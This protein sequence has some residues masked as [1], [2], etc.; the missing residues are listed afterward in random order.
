MLIRKKFCYKGREFDAIS[1]DTKALDSRTLFVK[2]DLNAKYTQDLVLEFLDEAPCENLSDTKSTHSADS[3]NSKRADSL[4][5]IHASTLSEI[6]T[7]PPFIIGITGTNGK[8]SSA[9]CMYSIL[10]D[11]GF[12]VALLGTRGFFIN[13][14]QLKPKGLTTPSVL[15]L[16]EDFELA[17]ECDFF[18]MEVSSHAIV[19][20]RIAGVPFALKALTNITSDHLD[21]HK[22]L[23]EYIRVKNSFF[24]DEALKVINADE[25]NARANPANCFSYG[26]ESKSNLSVNAYSLK[27]GISAHLYF[28]THERQTRDLQTQNP[29]AQDLQTQSVREEAFLQSPLFGKHNLYNILCALLSVRILALKLAST[30]F[31]KDSVFKDFCALSLQD[32][33]VKAQNF[34]GVSGRMEVVSENP[35]VIVDFAHTHDGMEK[36]FES[37]KGRKIVVL[38]GAGGDRDPTKRPK[39]GAVAQTYAQRIYLTN[40][41]PRTENPLEIINQIAQGLDSKRLQEQGRLIIELNRLRALERAVS[42]LERDEVL[43]VLGKG[44]ESY[45]IIGTQKIPFDDREILKKLLKAH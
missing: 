2:S 38:F 24:S 3:T 17:K 7:L 42:E 21:F 30:Q 25:P 11:C 12:S 18:I 8:T 13:Q 45:Q 40:D 37:F 32:L 27:N 36:I 33:C 4:P 10:L 39:M 15:E 6:F 44:D 35:L 34:G 20:E 14:K 26:V 22:S 29:Q 43:L 19:Q 16:Y 31:A 5:C 28:Q 23:E 1:D 41:N 9:A